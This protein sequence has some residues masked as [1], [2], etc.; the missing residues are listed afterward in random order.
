MKKIP[1]VPRFAPSF[2]VQRPF[3]LWMTGSLAV[4]MAA[5]IPLRQPSSES[6]RNHLMRVL[7]HSR[8]DVS[9]T[10]SRIEISARDRG[11]S[12]LARVRGEQ[13]VL[14]LG[15]SVGGTLVVMD[16]ADSQPAIP[17]SLVVHQTRGGG[18][19]VLIASAQSADDWSAELPLAVV[20]DLRSLPGLV[21]RALL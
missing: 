14:V 12:V 13:S 1:L 19:D 2:G 15:S 5:M 17:L 4:I 16:E 18:A 9:E 6:E 10:L 7:R 21:D 3:R 11:L 8:F 20:D